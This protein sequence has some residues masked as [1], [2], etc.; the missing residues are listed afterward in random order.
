MLQLAFD[1]AQWVVW[2]AGAIAVAAL[3]MLAWRLVERPR[4]LS[5]PSVAA[6]VVAG[7]VCLA[8]IWFLGTRVQHVTLGSITQLGLEKDH[9]GLRTN[10]LIYSVPVSVTASW[11]PLPSFVPGNGVI[12]DLDHK[13]MTVTAQ[14]AV[15]GFIDFTKI[16]HQTATI[17]R[18][19]R[20]ITLSLPDPVVSNGTTYIWS[21]DGVQERTGVLNA[22]EQSLVG[23]FEALFGH[24]QV[25]FN[26]GPELT[27]AEAAA[28][29]RAQ[30]S[31]A[32]ASCGKQE[33]V[34]QLTAEFNLLPEYRGYTVHVN[35][36]KPPVP[37][38]SCS[39]L[40]HQLATAGR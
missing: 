34:Q 35:W 16:T 28:L 38:V 12:G 22:I 40:Q 11:H 24:S 14:V 7:T 33:I 26:I 21:V 30:H 9:A 20:T 29:A 36:G 23:P 31:E 32:L 18:Q 17:D 25:S 1:V 19:A 2:V 6:L 8:S 13:T 10:A 3:L 39:G 37:G 4:R 5:V 27:D 15:Y